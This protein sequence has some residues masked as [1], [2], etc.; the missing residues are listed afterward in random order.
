MEHSIA[1][2]ENEEKN[3]YINMNKEVDNISN[4]LNKYLISHF[5]EPK[6]HH[7]LLEAY[8]AISKLKLALKY[9]YFDC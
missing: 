2:T 6:Y 3:Y 7:E 8:C 9:V 5:C 4:S 1:I